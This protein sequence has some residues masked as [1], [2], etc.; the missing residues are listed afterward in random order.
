MRLDMVLNGRGLSLISIAFSY[1][2]CFMFSRVAA[3]SSQRMRSQ[4]LT[5]VT[6]AL[7]RNQANDRLARFGCGTIV[8]CE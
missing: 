6:G 8:F 5:L 7:C 1:Q 2:G 4:V 3:I